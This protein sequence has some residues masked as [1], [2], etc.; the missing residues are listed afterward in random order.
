MK[1]SVPRFLC[2]EMLKGLGRWLRAAGYD[3]L[4]LEDGNDDAALLHR[5]VEEGR[6]LLT[7]DRPLMEYRDAPGT[8]VLLH[9]N[10]LHECAEELTRRLDIDWQHRPFSR[11][12]VCNTPLLEAT[13]P[14]RLQIPEDARRD[15]LVL[16]CPSCDKLYWE[17]SHVWRMRRQLQR[18][19]DGDFQPT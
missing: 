7:R 9:C 18:W 16:Y 14:Q 6:L 4:I 10:E 5:A 8:V 11:C 13:P 12:M 19:A 15:E 1:T 3:T 2:D 17:G